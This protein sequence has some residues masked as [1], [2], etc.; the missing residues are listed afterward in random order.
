MVKVIASYWDNYCV[1]CMS[2]LCVWY[3]CMLLGVV[4]LFS[5]PPPER[6]KIQPPASTATPPYS[7]QHLRNY[8]DAGFERGVTYR[9]QAALFSLPTFSVFWPVFLSRERLFCVPNVHRARRRRPAGG[10]GI[11]L[12]GYRI[13]VLFLGGA[14]NCG[15]SR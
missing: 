7:R 4:C 10:L 11:F 5:V 12:G 8:S 13:K 15:S 2:L 14:V 6:Q 3:V 1:I 9:I